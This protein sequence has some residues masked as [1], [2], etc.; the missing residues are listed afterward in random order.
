MSNV[1]LNLV[2]FPPY[3]TERRNSMFPTE[4]L[5]RAKQAQCWR[6]DVPSFRIAIIRTMKGG[7]SY[8]H[9]NARRTNPSCKKKPIW[10]WVHF[11]V[12]SHVSQMA[13]SDIPQSLSLLILHKS[14]NTKWSSQ[15]TIMSSN[16][17]IRKTSMLNCIVLHSLEYSSASQDSADYYT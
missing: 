10:R 12:F 9:I 16:A 3:F 8:F 15:Y 17:E 4:H 14:A 7:K 5:D 1:F 13:Q 11:Q 2:K 6:Q